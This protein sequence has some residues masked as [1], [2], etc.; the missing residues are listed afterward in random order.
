MWVEA[1]AINR[2]VALKGEMVQSEMSQEGRKTEQKR[3]YLIEN[4]VV[5]HCGKMHSYEMRETCY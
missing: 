2:F 5:W 1:I 4:V 3:A